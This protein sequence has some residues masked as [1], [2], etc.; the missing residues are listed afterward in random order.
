MM[1]EQEQEQEQ[2]KEEPT[3]S[4]HIREIPPKLHHQWKVV[5]AFYGIS[6]ENVVLTALADYCKQQLIEIRSALDDVNE[7]SDGAKLDEG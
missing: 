5:A 2:E 7:N 4:F 3:K 1:N 6:M